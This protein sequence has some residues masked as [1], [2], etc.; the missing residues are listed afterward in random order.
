LLYDELWRLS[1][2]GA[3]A[4]ASKLNQARRHPERVRL[5]SF[6]DY[7]TSAFMEALSRMRLDGDG[8]LFA[9]AFGLGRESASP[10]G[11]SGSARPSARAAVRLTGRFNARGL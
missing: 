2:R 5:V 4:A 6:D 8:V 9:G 11:A 7:E 1:R 10:R 3:V